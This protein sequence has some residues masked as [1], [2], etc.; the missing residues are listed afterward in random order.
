MPHVIGS[1]LQ[2]FKNTLKKRVDHL[3]Y[4]VIVQAVLSQLWGI[5]QEEE[6]GT[7]PNQSLQGLNVKLLLV[8]A[9]E[10]PRIGRIQ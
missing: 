5:Q 4:Q 3:V 2:C 8:S 9:K 6:Y 10:T 1:V 7:L